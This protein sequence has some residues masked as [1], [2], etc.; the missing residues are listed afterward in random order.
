MLTEIH[1]LSN[2]SW[3]YKIYLKSLK[4][5][6]DISLDQDALNKLAT[7]TWELCV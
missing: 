7:F 5:S 4:G 6:L 3:K 2:M 1:F